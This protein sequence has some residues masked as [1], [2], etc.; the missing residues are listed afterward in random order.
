VTR[1]L[2]LEENNSNFYFVF[3]SVFLMIETHVTVENMEYVSPSNLPFLPI[4]ALIFSLY[5]Y[6]YI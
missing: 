4:F 1:L 5:I 6:I 2:L 3:L